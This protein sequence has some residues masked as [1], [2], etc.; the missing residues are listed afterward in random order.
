MKRT[1]ILTSTSPFR[2]A[3]LE[4]FS[5]P[6]NCA[7]PDVDETPLAGETPEQLVR[8]LSLAKAMVIAN[9]QPDSIVIGSDQVAVFNNEILGKPHTHDN[10]VAQLS[11]FSGHKVQFLTGLAVVCGD[12]Q[13][14]DVEAVDVYFKDLSASQIEHYLQKEQPYNCAG[15]FKSEALGVALF[16][17]ID[18]RDPNTLIGLPMIRLNE[19]LLALGEDILS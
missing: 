8:R 18:S 17:K 12:Q 9:Q 14:V 19:M 7:K 10:A 2:R 16:D 6:F 11:K 1:L 5:I 15:S 13:L 4:K 3:L